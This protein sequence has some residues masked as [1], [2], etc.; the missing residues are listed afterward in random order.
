MSVAPMA[1][2]LPITSLFAG[3]HIMVGVLKGVPRDQPS[4]RLP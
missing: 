3:L 1:G 2:F 4:T